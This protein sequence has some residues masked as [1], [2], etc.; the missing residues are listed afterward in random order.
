M[1]NSIKSNSNLSGLALQNVLALADVENPDPGEDGGGKEDK[2][3]ER[4]DYT[5]TRD[6]YKGQV[7]F[8]CTTIGVMCEGDGIIDCIEGEVTECVQA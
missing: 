5:H 4:L 1:N 2:S 3:R 7:R 6:I 8:R